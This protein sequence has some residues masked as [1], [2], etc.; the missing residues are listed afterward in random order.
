MIFRYLFECPPV[1][2]DDRLFQKTP[3]QCLESNGAEIPI[4]IENVPHV[5]EELRKEGIE[6]EI[7]KCKALIDTGASMCVIS[8]AIAE[9][10]HLHFEK[11]TP[12]SYAEGGD[13]RPTYPA[14]ITFEWGVPYF[15]PVVACDLDNRFE[16]FIGRDILAN[17]DMNYNGKEGLITIND[18]NFTDPPSDKPG[19][20]SPPKNPNE[21]INLFKY[22]YISTLT[23]CGIFKKKEG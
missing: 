7:Y 13:S 12:V 6:V 3:S 8:T 4:T 2:V 5:I 14:I 20:E 9:K 15:V 18:F 22:W 19:E 21:P 1:K 17:W 16:C 10:L 23:F 11:F